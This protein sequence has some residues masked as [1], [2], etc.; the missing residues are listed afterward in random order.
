MMPQLLYIIHQV[1]N[2][3]KKMAAYNISLEYI[4]KIKG[5]Q[6]MIEKYP[7]SFSLFL[8]LLRY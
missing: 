2:I 4:K 5:D 3:R 8:S 7:P 1:G 6:L